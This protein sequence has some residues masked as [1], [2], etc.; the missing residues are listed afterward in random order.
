VFESIR[1]FCESNTYDESLINAL[2]EQIMKEQTLDIKTIVSL[3]RSVYACRFKND[4]IIEYLFNQS[5]L[6]I[7]AGAQLKD[8]AF[9]SYVLYCFSIFGT[10]TQYE[11]IVGK[12]NFE[13]FKVP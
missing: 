6:H 12:C 7:E 11:T 10:K 1:N 9:V 8:E 13:T 4:T 3:I 5:M 2:F